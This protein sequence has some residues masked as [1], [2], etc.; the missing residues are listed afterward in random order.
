MIF[1]FLT[2][3]LEYLSLVWD[4]CSSS[5]TTTN[6]T[7]S[8][9]QFITQYTSFVNTAIILL[10]V[11]F[12]YYPADL[13]QV[14]C[15]GVVSVLITMIICALISSPSLIFSRVNNNNN[16]CSISLSDQNIF[17][18]SA[19]L[20]YNSGTVSDQSQ[21]LAVIFVTLIIDMCLCTFFTL[22]LV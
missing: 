13:K 15:R 14:M 2:N 6:I 8:L 21:H 12:V 11:Y 9:Y 18:H 4:W 1:F 16:I 19:L 3:I 22:Q 5:V 7:C 10:V 17:N 20:F